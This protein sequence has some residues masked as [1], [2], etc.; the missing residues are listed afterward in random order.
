MGKTTSPVL[1]VMNC[2]E[3]PPPTGLSVLTN[4]VGLTL[5]FL[6]DVCFDFGLLP[7]LAALMLD[8]PERQA[9]P[10][11]RPMANRGCARQDE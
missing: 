1:M 7:M 3:Y 11:Q 4:T 8:H 9:K 5:G 2:T 6:V 10:A